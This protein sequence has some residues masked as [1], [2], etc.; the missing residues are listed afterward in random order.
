MSV[1]KGNSFPIS[2]R[3]L[4]FAF[5]FVMLLGSNAQAS[6]INECIDSCFGSNNCAYN[7][8]QGT[9]YTIC[10]SARDRCVEQCNRN[11]NGRNEEPPP[12]TGAYGAIAYDKTSGA[13]GM[14]DR[15]Q[16]RKSAEASALSNCKKH[17]HDC[18]IV[19]SFSKTCAAVAS[20][21]GNRTAWA[22]ADNPKQA[23]LDA[24]K[25]C[26]ESGS[27]GNSND[28]SRCFMQLY[29]CYFP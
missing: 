25:K 29:N 24:I 18:E 16:D 21:T 19:E 3:P 6:A 20:G 7:E 11:I 9:P 23:G 15:S 17:G 8:T 26:G 4:L 10:Q 5:A 27:S 14:A 28:H 13:W 12:V 2:F 1:D 22:V